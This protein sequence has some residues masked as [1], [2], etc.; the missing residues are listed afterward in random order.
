VDPGVLW[1]S[2]AEA[3]NNTIASLVQ[4]ALDSILHSYF[5]H[6]G[7]AQFQFDPDARAFPPSCE[8]ADF[9]VVLHHLRPLPSEISVSVPGAVYL[10]DGGIPS[11]VDGADYPAG[12]D[13]GD[14]LDNEGLLEREFASVCVD[15]IGDSCVPNDIAASSS[16]LFCQSF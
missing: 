6:Y 1:Q 3:Q 4:H 2:P 15:P 16:I 12:S 9:N 8:A 11:I 5:A 7:A 14:E 10:I 13:G